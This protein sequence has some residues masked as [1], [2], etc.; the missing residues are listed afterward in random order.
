MTASED[1]AIWS[2]LVERERVIGVVAR[3]GE[4]WLQLTPAEREDLQAGM[5]RGL[6]AV[7]SALTRL[8][9]DW[10]DA[11]LEAESPP[12]PGNGDG[13]PESDALRRPRDAV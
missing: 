2:L 5:L 6:T 12:N 9:P 8:A 4:A 1:G 7:E 13:G 10:F 3:A 11:W